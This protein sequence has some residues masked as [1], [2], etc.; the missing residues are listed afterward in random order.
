VK[1]CRKEHLTLSA[2]VKQ[3][4]DNYVDRRWRIEQHRRRDK[5]GEKEYQKTDAM[6]PYVEGLVVM[7]A[8]AQA[9]EFEG[10]IDTIAA[11]DETWMF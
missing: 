6:C 5:H 9:A 11:V 8:Q 10:E 2:D 4:E 3:R 7:F 1:Q